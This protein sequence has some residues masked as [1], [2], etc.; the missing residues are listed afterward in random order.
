MKQKDLFMI[1]IPSFIVIVFWIGLTI[2]HNSVSSTIPPALN[3]QIRPINP[4]FDS[5]VITELK[6]RKEITPMFEA[7]GVTQS[8]PSAI[9]VIPSI[10]PPVGGG[11]LIR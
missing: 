1:L 9:P 5:K 4:N 8:S 10:A 7:P 3:I 11:L 6:N 2:Y